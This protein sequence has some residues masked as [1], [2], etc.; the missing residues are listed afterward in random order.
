MQSQ[1]VA[2]YN[3][4]D[5]L[6]TGA[7]LDAAT[8][9]GTGYSATVNAAVNPD[10]MQ[11]CCC[12]DCQS[13]RQPDGVPG[14][15]AELR[16]HPAAGLRP[17]DRA[18]IP[19][20]TFYQ[21]FGDLPTDCAAVQ[22]MVRQARI[23]CEVLRGY[24]GANPPA[25][26]QANALAVAEK[27]YLLAAYQALLAGLGTSADEVRLATVA[28]PATRSALA[29]RLGLT[30]D[31]YG[32]GRPDVLDQLL[33][34]PPTAV[35]PPPAARAARAAADR[36][37]HRAAVRAGGTDVTRNPL[38]DGPV[39]GD[40]AGIIARWNLDGVSW[41]RNTDPDGTIYLWLAQPGAGELDA[42]LYKDKGLT[43]LVA[44]GQ[45]SPPGTGLPASITLA[46]E[47]NSGL[48]GAIEVT[49]AT[50]T[51]AISFG[52]IP[53]LASW[54]LA[55]LRADWQTEDHPADP[56]TA[57]TSAVPLAQ[58]P[59]GVTI[60]A[61][62]PAVSYNS[63]AQVLTSTGVL[64]PADLAQLLQAAQ[65][66]AAA[67]SYVSAVNAL[68]VASQR[69]PVID[70][71]VIGPDDFRVPFTG[72]AAGNQPFGLWVT[73]RQWV[74]TQLQA[75]QTAQGSG[76]APSFTGMLG[77][78]QNDLTYGPV[79]AKPWA[80]TTPVDEPGGPVGK[81]GPGRGR[82]GH[83]PAARLRPMPAARRSSTADGPVARRPGGQRG[84]A[85]SP[86]HRRRLARGG[87]AADAGGQDQVL[88]RLAGRGERRC[89][90]TSARARSSSRCAS[91]SPV[92]GRR[93]CRRARR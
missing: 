21:P 34:A 11:S 63:A 32:A 66:N 27:I 37:E 19:E 88:R 50:E 56:Y 45:L 85:G 76:S 74:D 72:A 28:D 79:T 64:A 40:P 29:G 81:P 89:R 9:A 2:M 8:A 13:A 55:T 10:T 26:A 67:A 39:I 22:T 48:S 77:W 49:Q 91:R 65:G 60:P 61:A 15:P 57:G 12:A 44:F 52:A 36:G 84:T 73:R 53:L 80:P 16:H 38:S 4:L 62:V 78:M 14:R 71:D 1:A 47:N 69:P 90:S 17:A 5:Q 20:E 93:C 31:P 3:A 42:A 41:G 87:V 46:P 70:P 6:V 86:A 75:L 43:K 23:C 33:L 54:Q 30:I 83:H 18:A 25:A 92:T 59:A 24:L 7:R 82:A 35:P 51:E 58:L 68:Y